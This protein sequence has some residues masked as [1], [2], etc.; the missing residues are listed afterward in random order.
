M[1]AHHD[2]GAWRGDPADLLTEIDGASIV[3]TLISRINQSRPAW[4]GLAACQGRHDLN[5]FPSRGEDGQPARKLCAACPV[6]DA[7]LDHAIEQPEYFGIWGGTPERQRR[8]L[9]R[10]HDHHGEGR[11]DR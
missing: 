3:A 9:R 11:R 6:A 2:L 7:C 8:E 10:Q 5:F 1:N 4:H